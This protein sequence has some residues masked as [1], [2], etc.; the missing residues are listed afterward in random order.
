MIFYLEQFKQALELMNR[1]VGNGQIPGAME[2]LSY[3]KNVERDTSTSS[4]PTS[5]ARFQVEFSFST[6]FS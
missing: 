6:K 1:S 3:L 2:S 5:S 4:N